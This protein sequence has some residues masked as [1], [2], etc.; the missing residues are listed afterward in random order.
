M[1]LV[2]ILCNG[3]KT[4]CHVQQQIQTGICQSCLVKLR[5]LKCTSKPSNPFGGLFASPVS[6]AVNAGSK[7]LI[8]GV[9][10]CKANEEKLTRPSL[11]FFDFAIIR[12]STAASSAVEFNA[13]H[14]VSVEAERGPE[15]DS[16][17]RFSSRGA[18]CSL[19]CS[20]GRADDIFCR[21]CIAVCIAHYEPESCYS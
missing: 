11:A 20:L 1:Q 19:K 5:V 7:S 4:V 17:L 15:A 8:N 18:A 21:S 2:Q 10:S 14:W 6:S 13:E 16:G 3:L 12:L 9:P